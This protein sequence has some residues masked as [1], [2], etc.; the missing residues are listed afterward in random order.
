M[1]ARRPGAH[2]LGRR[3]GSFSLLLACAGDMCYKSFN[4]WRKGVSE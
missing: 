3:S 2:E 4:L 1:K